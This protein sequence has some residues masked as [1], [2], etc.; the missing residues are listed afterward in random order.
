MK[1]PACGVALH[2]DARFCA[3]CGAPL[4][5]V[6][7]AGFSSYE[8]PWDAGKTASDA[9]NFHAEETIIP[10]FMPS[11]PASPTAEDVLRSVSTDAVTQTASTQPPDAVLSSRNGR[12]L[13]VT[14]LVL[15]L[16]GGGVYLFRGGD[17]LPLPEPAPA[18]AELAPSGLPEQQAAQN[19]ELVVSVGVEE[20]TPVE[21]A[22]GAAVP[23]DTVPSPASSSVPSSAPTPVVQQSKPKPNPNTKPKPSPGPSEPSQRKTVSVA[24]AT[25]TPPVE[26]GRGWQASLKAD[27]AAC[28]GESFFARI[29][30]REKVRWKYCA[31]DRWD[32]VPGCEVEGSKR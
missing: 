1:C 20:E 17:A 6:A 28:E 32:T 25:P 22:A 14:V 27:L 29:A 16:A 10:D 2:A 30:C 8:V 31:P 15:L 9:S 24:A 7:K 21:L 5:P 11:T 19:E 18:V 26:S 13:W 3:D 4:T 23:P 12:M